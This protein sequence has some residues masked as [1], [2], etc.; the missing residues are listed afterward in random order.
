[1]EEENN[2][3]DDGAGEEED[4]DTEAQVYWYQKMQHVLYEA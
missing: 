4:I 1:L 3:F 2:D